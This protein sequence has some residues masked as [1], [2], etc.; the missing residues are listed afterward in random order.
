MNFFVEIAEPFH[1][2]VKV[3]GHTSPNPHLSRPDLT[4]A[5]PIAAPLRDCIAHSSLDNDGIVSSAIW[6][7]RGP[8]SP[9]LP[10]HA[11]AF[12]SASASI[13]FASRLPEGLH[14]SDRIGYGTRQEATQQHARGVTGAVGMILR[15]P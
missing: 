4:F 12:P 15:D 10:D 11:R 14:S 3:H 2:A 9:L 5:S 1:V 6:I 8:Y 7:C 13:R